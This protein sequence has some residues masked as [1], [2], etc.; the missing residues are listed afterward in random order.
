MFR[1]SVLLRRG[2]MFVA[3]FHLIAQLCYGLPKVLARTDTE[4]DVVVYYLVQERVHHHEP[5]YL[6]MP[7]GPAF[8]D[9]RNPLY[10]YPP[11]LS[12]LFSLL[13]T[14][15][16]VT[17]A[18]LWTVLAYTSF[19][20]FSACLA[21]LARGRAT[22]ANTLMAGLVLG[23]SPGT[24]RALSLGQIDPILWALFGIALAIPSLRGTGTMAI[25]M[26]KLWGIWPL[27]AALNDDRRAWRGGLLMLLSGIG[28]GILGMGPMEFYK[29]C[30]YWLSY[31][32]PTISQGTWDADN[33]SLSFALLRALKTAG[34]WHYESGKLPVW[35]KIWLIS[36]GIG[37]PVIA[38]VCLRHRTIAVQMSA[39]G[40]AAILFGPICWTSYFPI[41]LTLLAALVG[42]K[43]FT[44][45]N[46]DYLLRA[47]QEEKS[48][49]VGGS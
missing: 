31:V 15:S 39:M 19:W 32:L 21:K 3:I 37:G 12:S 11:V 2:I 1:D 43:H 17:F 36:A 20:I 42:E 45:D 30:Q 16:F 14:I 48:Q 46:F 34:V 47:E 6:P 40:C 41:L 35:G 49:T 22:I 5:I 24:Q 13:P 8:F 23:L 27:V 26:V 7:S 28:V 18:R 38:W 10:I 25:A 33:R 44:R 4:R 29:S 9:T